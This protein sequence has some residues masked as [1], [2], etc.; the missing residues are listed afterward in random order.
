MGTDAKRDSAPDFGMEDGATNK[1]S[2][3]GWVTDVVGM[4]VV[5]LC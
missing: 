5:Y 4:T 3:A 2:L 1:K